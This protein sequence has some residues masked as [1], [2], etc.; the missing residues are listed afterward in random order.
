VPALVDL[1]PNLHVLDDLESRLAQDEP[2]SSWNRSRARA[3]ELLS[4][5]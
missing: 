3:R 1:P 4:D 5:S 2:W